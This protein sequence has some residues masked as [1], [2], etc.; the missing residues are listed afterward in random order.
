MKKYLSG[1]L[2]ISIFFVPPIQG[3][4]KVSRSHA[5][6]AIFAFTP[7]EINRL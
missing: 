2:V 7:I 1:I 4:I 5:S 3:D 6:R